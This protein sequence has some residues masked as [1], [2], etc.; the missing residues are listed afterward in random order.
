MVDERRFE[1]LEAKLDDFINY[2]YQEAEEQA[3]FRGKTASRLDSV[4]ALAEDYRA[5]IKRL[6]DETSLAR[7]VQEHPRLTITA[8]VALVASS[9]AGVIGMVV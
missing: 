2:M 6:F 1:R 7:F 5:D 9:L 3:E 8:I 4:C